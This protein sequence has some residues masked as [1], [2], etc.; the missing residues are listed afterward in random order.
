[1]TTASRVA[2]VVPCYQSARFLA[3]TVAGVQAQTMTDWRLVVVDDGSTDDPRNTISQAL[4]RDWRVTFVRQDNRGVAAARNAGAASVASSKYILFLDADDVLEPT[5]LST[6]VAWLEAHAEAGMAYCKPSF[7]D[8]Y[9]RPATSFWAPRL[10]RTPFGVG[11]IP[12]EEPVTPFGSIFCLAGIVPSLS[13]IRRGL[14]EAVGWWDETFGQHYEDTLL[15]LRLALQAEVHYVNRTLVRHRRHPGQSTGDPSKF[16]RQ[17]QKLYA[18]FR[19]ISSFDHAQRATV[20][21]AWKFRERRVIPMRACGAAVEN[22]RAGAAMTGAR[23]VAGAARI[24]VGSILLG[25]GRIL[26]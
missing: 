17:E 1:M 16:V 10:R 22:V 21:D 2:I 6:M 7:I 12:D 13:L 19:D 14:F 9:G 11:A 26:S 24:A 8:E 18:H 20:R 25:P 23:F 3:E 15:F 4:D 5:M